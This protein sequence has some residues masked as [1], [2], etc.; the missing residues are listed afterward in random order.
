MLNDV[1]YSSRSEMW[2]TPQA[3]FDIL[4]DEFNFTLDPCATQENAK[5]KKFFTKVEDGLVQD[6]GKEIVFCNPPYGKEIAKWSVL[7]LLLFV[8]LSKR[9]CIQPSPSTIPAAQAK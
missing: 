5:C 3:F 7:C 9:I 4:N 1:L 2:E 8:A 6:W